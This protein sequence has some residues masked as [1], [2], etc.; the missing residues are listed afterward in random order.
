MTDRQIKILLLVIPL[1]L[2][3][4]FVFD[5]M[6][7]T[8][9]SKRGEFGTMATEGTNRTKEKNKTGEKMATK[10]ITRKETIEILSGIYTAEIG[11]KELTGKNDG[12]RVEEYLASC[13]LGKG[14]AWCA[15]FVNWCHVRAGVEGAKSAYSPNWFPKE[16]TIYTQG[17]KENATPSKC[18]VF[19]LYYA[20]KKRI[21]HVGFID[22]YSD[23]GDYCITVEGNTNND[24]SREGDG[25]YRKR[26]LKNQIYRV[27][28]WV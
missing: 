10:E 13:G 1:T 19:G 8:N 14:Y 21:A 25:V 15:A 4:M 5:R 2:A 6:T 28:R 12:A 9:P 23:V 7:S 11:V 16:H 18:D 24:G 27:S 22:E 3:G 20:D 26:R 17:G